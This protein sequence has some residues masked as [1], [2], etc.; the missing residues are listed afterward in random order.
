MASVTLRAERPVLTVNIG[1]EREVG[2]PLTFTRAEFVE[3]GKAA[4]PTEGMF[5]FF[6]TYMGDV[7]DMLGDDDLSAL[8]KAWTDARAEI[9]EPGLGEPQA[10]PQS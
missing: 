3:M 10:S 5:G 1:D 4:D 2:V 7:V 6:R 8:I 9:G